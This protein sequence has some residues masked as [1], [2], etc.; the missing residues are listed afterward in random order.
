MNPARTPARYD[1]LLEVPDTKGAEI[2]DDE[3]RRVDP[4]LRTVEV[5]RLDGG[6]W[7]VVA[8]HAGDAPVRLAPFDAIELDAARWWL[9]SA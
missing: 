5:C 9:E 4:L 6:G 1:D 8:V 3:S 2:I 7:R